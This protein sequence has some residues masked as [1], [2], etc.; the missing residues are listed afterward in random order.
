MPVQQVD[1]RGA[2]EFCQYSKIQGGNK[3]KKKSYMHT[4]RHASTRDTIWKQSLRK[5]GDRDQS[6]GPFLF[7]E[8]VIVTHMNV[9]KH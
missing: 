7:T 2:T 8:C 6:V 5:V 1:V 4:L 9:S 3:K